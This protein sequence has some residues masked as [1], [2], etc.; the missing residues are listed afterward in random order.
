[1]GLGFVFQRLAKKVADLHD[2]FYSG[3]SALHKVL[4][5]VSRLFDL[6]AKYYRDSDIPKLFP[7]NL[8]FDMLFK[9]KVSMEQS[10]V[11][12]NDEVKRNAKSTIETVLW[13]AGLEQLFKENRQKDPELR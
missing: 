10:S 6:P 5:N 9:Q 4:S 13:S 8:K 11:K 12:I 3:S 7:S 2:E 1:M